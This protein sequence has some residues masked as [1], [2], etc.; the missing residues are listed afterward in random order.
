MRKPTR[1]VFCPLAQQMEMSAVFMSRKGKKLV[2][3]P[4]GKEIQQKRWLW[5]AGTV[6]LGKN[7]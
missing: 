7:G 3:E 2:E 1:R 6:P 5:Y 4:D